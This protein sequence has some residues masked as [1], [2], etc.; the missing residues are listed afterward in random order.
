MFNVVYKKHADM[1]ACSTMHMHAADR[2]AFL[3]GR[4]IWQVD[5]L[6]MSDSIGVTAK[7]A[8]LLARV[9]SPTC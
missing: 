7:M 5:R 1:H 4:K 8:A 6:M 3:Q 9:R 2:S